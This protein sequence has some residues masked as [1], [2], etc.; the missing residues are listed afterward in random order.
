MNDSVIKDESTEVLLPVAILSKYSPI[1]YYVLRA[2]G[3]I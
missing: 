3:V 2:K 1:W